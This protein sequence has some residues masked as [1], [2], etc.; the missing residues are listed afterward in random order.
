LKVELD[1]EVELELTIYLATH[2]LLAISLLMAAGAY[3]V[4]TLC[5]QLTR[6][7]L[8]ISEF[9]V[10]CSDRIG[11]A[12]RQRGLSWNYKQLWTPDQR[13]LS[14]VHVIFC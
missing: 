9:L 6:D 10:S 3:C 5:V 7:L 4:V 11:K 13:S 2:H 12:F 1:L 14:E 8:A